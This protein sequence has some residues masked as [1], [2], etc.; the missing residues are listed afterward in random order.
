MESS[1]IEDISRQA[2]AHLSLGFSHTDV[3]ALLR[4]EF[5][6]TQQEAA[7]AIKHL[8][9]EWSLSAQ[10]LALDAD[11]VRNYHV[12]MRLQLLRKVISSIDPTSVRT[13]L[14]ILESIAN[15]F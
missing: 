13:S 1:T 8:Y 9:S 6:C 14:Q 10:E 3:A 2:G 15:I 4:D 5:G 12:D 11:D 7:K